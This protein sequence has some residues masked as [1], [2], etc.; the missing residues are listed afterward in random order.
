[1]S[2]THKK[3]GKSIEQPFTKLILTN[4]LIYHSTSGSQL[5]LRHPNSLL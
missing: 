5:A 4:R 2:R 3:Y 1:M